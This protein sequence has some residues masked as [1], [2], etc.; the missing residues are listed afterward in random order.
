MDKRK[1]TGGQRVR[2]KSD[3]A[4]IEQVLDPRTRIILFKMLSR[5]VISEINGV[6]STGK[7][8]NVYHA[9][10]AS[11]DHRAIKIY[12]TSILTFKDRDRYV[13]G[14]FR[15][16][17]GY[18]KGN[19]RKMVATWAEKETRNL[20]RLCNAG[21]SCPT[22]YLLRSHV[23]VMDFIGSEGWPAPLLKDT[24]LS[25]SKYRE[26]YLEC[27]LLI[28]QI[29]NECR[30]VHGDLSEFN[31]LYHEGHLVVIDVSQSVEH[32]HPRALDFLRKDCTNINEYFRKKGVPSMSLRELFN[33]VTDVTINNSNIDEYLQKAMEIAA[34]RPND[35]QENTNDD[36]VFG[37]SFIPQRLDE[38]KHF[39]R[40]VKNAKQGNTEV[41]YQ[42]IT[43]MNTTLSG[44]RE[45]P[46]MLQESESDSDSDD[47][48]CTDGSEEFDRRTR[49]KNIV[50]STRTMTKEEKKEHKKQVKIE[51]RERRL[52]KTPKHIKKRRDKLAHAKRSK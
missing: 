43:G 1:V 12:K 22:P 42:T 41:L 8:A 17:R 48:D 44:P 37:K 49:P 34:N 26:L 11:G 10:T 15:F 29:Y 50:I 27:I 7:E 36:A 24:D 13:S 2:D 4:T 39:E 23:L 19:P 30:L 35:E 18:C 16:R 33:F 5:N 45:M 3:R 52:D 6:I 31:L 25:E 40:D 20:T 46:D 47:S 38:V 28:R 32:D 21:V 51:N 14:E 9:T